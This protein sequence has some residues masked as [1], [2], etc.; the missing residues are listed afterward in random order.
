MT[1]Q[2]R[3]RDPDPD[4]WEGGHHPHHCLHPGGGPEGRPHSRE[5]QVYPLLPFIASRT[6]KYQLGGF[7]CLM[8]GFLGSLPYWQTFNLRYY[9]RIVW[10]CIMWSTVQ[11]TMISKL[12]ITIYA[13]VIYTG[14]CIMFW[15]RGY[16]LRGEVGG[17][18]ALEFLSFLGP[19]KWHRA[20]RRVPFGAQKT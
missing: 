8:T 5:T 4:E 11:C 9:V 18:W 14:P 13:P 16:T 19:V 7:H 17:G 1:M 20:D 15:R 6:G 10:N 3:E 2:F 12:V